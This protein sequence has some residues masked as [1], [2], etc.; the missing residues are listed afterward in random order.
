MIIIITPA[1]D[2]SRDL[3]GRRTAILPPPPRRP[4]DGSARHWT[5]GPG[6]PISGHRHIHIHISTRAGAEDGFGSDI[7]ISSGF[8]YDSFVVE[9]EILVVGRVP[10][11]RKTQGH[12]GGAASDRPTERV[13]GRQ[14]LTEL[15]LLDNP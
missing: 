4:R 15:F 1:P 13:R 5:V 14:V 2:T 8:W 10:V 3:E 9:V 7:S 12:P 11:E 6:V